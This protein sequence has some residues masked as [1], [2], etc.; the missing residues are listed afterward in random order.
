MTKTIEIIQNDSRFDDD[1]YTIVSPDHESEEDVGSYELPDGYS[2]LTE[3]G[4]TTV[5]IPND[6]YYHL[7]RSH[8]HHIKVTVKDEPQHEELT[9]SLPYREAYTFNDLVSE[10]GVPDTDEAYNALRH[11][12]QV[13][14]NLVY[15]GGE[16]SI[17]SVEVDGETF[18]KE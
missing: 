4:M 10:L 5:N 16:T 11:Q 7:E 15:E 3:A 9:V 2:S 12:P 8:E 1:K 17:D 13:S 18:T 14:V 6:K